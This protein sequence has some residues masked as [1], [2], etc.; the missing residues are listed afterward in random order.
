MSK[1]HSTVL[2]TSGANGL[3]FVSLYSGAGGL[4]LGFARA[5][6]TPVFANDID[7]F[8][9]QTYNRL[10]EVRDPEW[11]EAAKRFQGHTAVSGD[12]RIAG[13]ALE[14]GMADL[15]IGGPPCQGFSVA[16]RMDPNDPRSRHVFDFLGLVARIKPQAFVMENVAALARNRRWADIIAAL[17]DTAALDYKVELV[18]L[19]ASHWGVPQARERMFLVGVPQDGADFLL[20]DPPSSDKP[21]TVR[22]ALAELPPAGEEGN[23][24]LCTASITLAKSPVLRR[25]PYAGMLFNG[26]GRVMNLDRPAP[27]LPATMGG[28]R[29][30]IVDEGQLYRRGDPWIESYHERLFKHGMPALPALPD[31]AS[32]RRI[33]VE[34]AAAIQTFPHDV[35]WQG[36][37]SARY[38]QIGN[39]VPP[40]LAYHVAAA[41]ARVLQENASEAEQ[42]AA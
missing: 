39:A 41:V 34:E 38:R 15:V 29:T 40:R 16:G 22:D 7:P 31:Q 10:H 28:N 5:G 19:N 30:P 20:P 32:L 23:D 37:Q 4:D 1:A 26:Q 36:R 21:P 13:A 6:F 12:V 3:S 2:P 11:A 18:V 8:A 33:T 35:P 25:S 9:V 14:E 42:P 24:S 17:K 27:T